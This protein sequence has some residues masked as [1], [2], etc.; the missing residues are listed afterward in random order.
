MAIGTANF[1]LV[2]F[3]WVKD[4]WRAL[5]LSHKGRPIWRATRCTQEAPKW[6]IEWWVLSPATAKFKTCTWPSWWVTI[7]SS[8][9]MNL[10]SPLLKPFKLVIVARVSK[11]NVLCKEWLAV[12]SCKSCHIWLQRLYSADITRNF[13]ILPESLY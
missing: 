9:T 12:I 2:V 5:Q 11:Y 1:M 13:G 8:V 3:C 6:N 7:D 10:S 4:G